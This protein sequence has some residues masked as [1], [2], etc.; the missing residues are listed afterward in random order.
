MM[1]KEGRAYISSQNNFTA[2]QLLMEVVVTLQ[3]RNTG[4]L[5]KG[6][7]TGAFISIQI[8][9]VNG[10]ELGDQEC[11]DILFLCFGVHHPDLPNN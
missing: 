5:W 4:R 9:K 6:M 1:L 7:K 8:Y 11:R 10:I 2:Q 3:A